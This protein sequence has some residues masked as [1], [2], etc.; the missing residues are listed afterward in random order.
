MFRAAVLLQILQTLRANKL[1][2]LLTMFG[3]GWGVLSIILMTASGEGFRKAQRDGMAQ[4]GRDILIIWGGRTSLQ[5]EGFQAGRNIR[6]EYADYEA[7]RDH[8]RLI[9]YVSPEVMRW[10]L[11]AKTPINYGTF[12]V[13]GVLPEYQIMRTITVTEGRLMNPSD[14]D[15]ARAVCVIG[16]EV[17]EQLFRGGHSV[18]ET[19]SLR[20]HPFTVIGIMPHKELNNNYAGQDHSAIF[21]PYETL[22]RLYSSPGLGQSPD[23]IDNLIATPVRHEV[24]EEAER[25]VR[26]VLG[27]KW[28]FDPADDDA[29][30]IWNT[31][32]Q[33]EMMEIMFGSMQ[34]F[35]G[36]VGVV[37]L[38]LGAVGVINIMLVSVRERT[39]EIGIRKALGA[40]NRD[41]LGQFFL[42]ALGITFLAGGTGLLL[43]WGLCAAINSLPFERMV[44]AGM[45]I[46]PAIAAAAMGSLVVVGLV[47]GIY[48]AY[49]AAQLDP[50][51][52]LRFEVN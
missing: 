1:R 44:F 16:S 10:D 29:V 12:N 3:I 9:R 34:W 25:E 19:L 13:R 52:A 38:M 42:E 2:S 6:L 14:N 26:Q 31:A 39:M 11:V 27:R 46:S 4:L 8:A 30:F 7:I 47:S 5:A 49:I 48:P 23:L 50:I 22:R 21:I 40:R 43:G 32:R 35:L 18:G 45:I 36:T 51:E 17:N 33:I 20:G 24:Y 15:E 28:Q 37:T 41:I